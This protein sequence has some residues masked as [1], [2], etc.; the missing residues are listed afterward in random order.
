MQQ[1]ELDARQRALL[2]K[3]LAQAERA[4]L[5]ALDAARLLIGSADARFRDRLAA[6]RRALNSGKSVADA[7]LRN[8]L[9]LPWEARLV[10]AAEVSGKL[11]QCYAALAT[12][13]SDQSRRSRQLKNGILLPLAIFVLA[14]FIAP[15]SALVT[16]AITGT[17]YLFLTIGRLL[18]FFGALFLLSWSWRRLSASGAD[19]SLFRL[20]LRIPFF[21]RLI[22]R[23]QQRDYLF[24]L[25]W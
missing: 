8:G 18:L 21:G 13:H 3:Q 4:G 14:V 6:F 10:Q 25:P 23:Q 1:A 11:A 20:L 22:R 19:N 24:S 5:T 17:R 15:L 12:R 7:G 9:F 16:G 2:F